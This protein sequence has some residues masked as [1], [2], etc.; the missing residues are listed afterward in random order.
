MIKMFDR[1][2]LK[3]VTPCM[4]KTMV[5][6]L[7][8][9]LVLLLNVV[10]YHVRLANDREIHQHQKQLRHRV[11]AAETNDNVISNSH[12]VVHLTPLADIICDSDALDGLIDEIV[13]DNAE[14]II[15]N[16]RA[17]ADAVPAVNVPVK[18]PSRAKKL[19]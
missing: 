5:E 8:G 1:D 16:P 12:D 4:L 15:D 10:E 2:N 17:V 18:R 14:Q 7:T 11:V 9:Y 13:S 3:L 19:P 6:G